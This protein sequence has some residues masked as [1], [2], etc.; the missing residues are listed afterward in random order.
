MA[1]FQ[2]KSKTRILAMLG[3]LTS[4]KKFRQPVSEG[5]G[6]AL[7][8]YMIGDDSRQ[9]SI[10]LYGEDLV[11]LEEELYADIAPTGEENICNCSLSIEDIEERCEN[12][13][14]FIL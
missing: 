13:A 5:G 1:L 4:V 11:T 10:T 9:Y 2:R 3:K 8:I 6:Q 7:T 12:C 14:K